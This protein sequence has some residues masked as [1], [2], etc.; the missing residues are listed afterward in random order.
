MARM[1]LMIVAGAL[2]ALTLLLPAGAS[3]QG[4]DGD[5]SAS[6]NQ[7]GEPG[8]PGT[9]PGQ[10]G[11]P[12]GQGGTPPGQ[13]NGNGKPRTSGRADVLADRDDGSQSG[14]AAGRSGGS[15]GPGAAAGGAGAGGAGAIV[16]S[17]SLPFTG[18]EAWMIL[19]AGL[20][21]LL[22]GVAMRRAGRGAQA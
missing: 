14:G 21:A 5:G 11:T 17:G 12:P 18:F 22:G 10:G 20:A 3:A 4:F 1:T 9:P 13:G 6:A 7:Y 19:A 16:K 15:G 8:P 2:M